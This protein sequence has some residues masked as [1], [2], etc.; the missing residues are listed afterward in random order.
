MS[1]ISARIFGDILVIP[2]TVTN[3]SPRD[4]VSIAICPTMRAR[5]FVYIAEKVYKIYLFQCNVTMIMKLSLF[6]YRK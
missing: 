6:L 3:I 1:H 2:L 5:N 4:I